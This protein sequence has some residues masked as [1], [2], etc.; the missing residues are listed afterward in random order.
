MPKYEYKWIPGS[1]VATDVLEQCS[2]LYSSH[3]GY[4]SPDAPSRPRERVRLS[5]ERLRDWMNSPDA[6]LVQARANGD[7]VGY[8][9]AVR[10]K[11]PD[12]GVI[13]WVTQLV[14]HESHRNRGI[15]KTLLFSV[16]GF[17][18][19][20]AWGVV[21][22][23]PYAVRALE[24]AT[25][26]RCDPPRIHKNHRKL[27]SVGADHVP[28]LNSSVQSEITKSASR[29]KTEFFVDHSGLEKMINDVTTSEIPWVL[30]SI[31]DGW[32]WFAF[33]FYDQPQTGLTS[34]EVTQ[35]LNAS[36]QATRSAYSRMLL[37]A[38]H[39]WQKHT[40]VE[41]D[42]IAETLALEPG[43]SILDFG[44]GVGRHCVELSRRGFS[45]TGVDYVP[46][47]IEQGLSNVPSEA[48]AS[49]TL[50]VGDCRDVDLNGQFDGAICL[51]DVVG[52]YAEDEANL[53]V[54]SNL[55]RH[56][57][58]GGRVLISVM[59]FELTAKRAKHWFS[60]TNEP[61]KLL[62]LPASRIMEETGDVFD[63]DFYMIDKES[64]L[65][66][67]KE[68]FGEGNSLPIELVIRDRRFRR[69]KIENLCQEAGL[70]VLSSRFVRAGSWG[71]PLDSTDDSAKEILVL[72]EKPAISL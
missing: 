32:E 8:A 21:T 42:Y 40:G 59:N 2:D 14:V 27:L 19:H 69:S 4:W 31:D 71:E 54:L 37:N 51:Y 55:A 1:M 24:T 65:V 47:F 56:V 34:G 33:T 18:D 25:R 3:Y 45:C 26:R 61:D 6:S 44:C 10:T 30:G 35:M 12:Y 53:R 46:E 70:T 39:K 43:S 16:W 50:R 7:L 5:A 11:V 57:K 62:S 49:I 60:L 68:Q 38:E 58:P 66:F 9:L 29:V 22:P 72:C 28:Y 23:S 41:A 20:F 64:E 67:R 48:A 36:E 15:G 13:S 17:S 52:S 63:P